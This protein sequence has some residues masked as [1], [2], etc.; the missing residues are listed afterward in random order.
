MKFVTRL[1]RLLM[2]K[3]V[4]VGYICL[5]ILLTLNWISHSWVWESWEAVPGGIEHRHNYFN[6]RPSATLAFFAF[7]AFAYAVY[8]FK[9]R[10]LIWYSFVEILAGILAGSIA[11]FVLRFDSLT[12]WLALLAAAYIVVRGFENWSKARA[13]V[14]LNS[15]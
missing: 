8:R 11:L 2:S 13:G 12:H 4:G 1:E 6:F 14:A 5:L 9:L 15:S 7:P 3:V 10:N